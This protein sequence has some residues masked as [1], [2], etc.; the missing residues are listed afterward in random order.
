[1]ASTI[2]L[3]YALDNGQ[4]PIG[5]YIAAWTLLIFRLALSIFELKCKK[6]IKRYKDTID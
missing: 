3:L 1:M 5:C 4:I 2:I 6:D